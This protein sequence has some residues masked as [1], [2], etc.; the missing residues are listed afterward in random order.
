MVIEVFIDA[1]YS[2]VFFLADGT[3][4]LPDWDEGNSLSE[5]IAFSTEGAYISAES[6]GHVKVT[7]SNTMD[8][9]SG[10]NFLKE[11]SISSP[12]KVFVLD[13]LDSYER[14]KLRSDRNDIIIGIYLDTLSLCEA[15]EILILTDAHLE[16]VEITN[17]NYINDDNGKIL[18]MPVYEKEDF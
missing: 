14:I 8:I 18:Y 12:N 10:K 1:T 7:F 16:P 13:S 9:A 2:Q 6:E 5:G 4:N 15:K 11:I 17:L 3:D